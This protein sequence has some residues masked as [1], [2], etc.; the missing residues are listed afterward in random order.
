MNRK[1]GTVLGFM[2]FL[3]GFVALILGVI[4]LGLKPLTFID[5]MTGSMGGTLVKLSMVVVG[6]IIFYMSR[7]DRSEE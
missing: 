4:G 2:L 6:F 1:Y 5:E 3:T 7:V